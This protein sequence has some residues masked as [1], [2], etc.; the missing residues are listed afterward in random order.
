MTYQ[1]F[2]RKYRPQTW[3]AVIGQEPITTTLANALA[4]DRAHH[5]YLFAGARGVGKTTVARI[6]AKALNCAA[7]GAAAEPC[8]ACA[9]CTDITDGRSL[10][11]Q[12]IDGASNTSVDDVREIRE[13]VKYLP[14]SGRYKVYIIDEVHMLSNAAFNALLKTLEE[15][16]AH[17]IFIFATT[18][19]EK[20]PVTILSRCQRYDF[21]RVAPARIV[22]TLERIAAAEGLQ[23]EIEALWAIAKEAE[24]SLRDAESLLDQAVAFGG[25]ALT[26]A[27]V[28]DLLGAADRQLVFAL[29]EAIVRRDAAAVVDRIAAAFAGGVNLPRLAHEL[30]EIMRSAWLITACGTLPEEKELPAD[31]VDRLRAIA[32]VGTALDFQQWFAIAYR[33]ADDVARTKW[34]R[35]AMESLCLQMVQT[36]P[37][38]A[39]DALLTRVEELLGRDEGRLS[40][41]CAAESEGET[42]EE[43][44]TPTSW[45]GFLTMLRAVKP[46]MVAIVEH[47]QL[48]AATPERVELQYTKDSLYGDMLRELDRARQMERLLQQYFGTPCRL[49]VTTLPG[50]SVAETRDQERTE[51]A[52]RGQSVRA[53][54]TEHTL[55]REAAQLFGA[56]ITEVK[57]LAP[58]AGTGQRPVAEK[59]PQ[60]EQREGKP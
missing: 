44:K 59:V 6:L 49:V 14:A 23:A 18:E 27:T 52:H 13:R 1:P 43:K 2:A 55:V 24:G 58:E 39:V 28:R 12:E 8:N 34:P 11:I 4:A 15:P 53:A 35:L 10:D 48:I 42:G 31:D 60:R 50:P 36:G 33:F 30:L 26:V 5:A 40:A 7:R 9:H 47:G 25:T 22:A 37:V 46:Q 20:I 32:Q 3:A 45:E 19:P 54:A 17:A 21:R 51:R 16:P 38:H 57:T 41:A 29:A 56:E